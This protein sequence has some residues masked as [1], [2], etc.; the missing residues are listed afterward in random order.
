MVRACLGLALVRDQPGPAVVRTVHAG[1]R[2]GQA[3]ARRR[4]GGDRLALGGHSRGTAED[5]RR[6]EGGVGAPLTDARLAG[7]WTSGSRRSL[8]CSSSSISALRL[9]PSF[10]FWILSC[11][12]TIASSSISGRG[13]QPGR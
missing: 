13:G 7:P 9:A 2:T 12:L 11:S 6:G 5:R 10:M 3:D 8:A 4:L 1:T